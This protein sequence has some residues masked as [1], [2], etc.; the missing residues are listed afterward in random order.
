MIIEKIRPIIFE[1]L[2][3]SGKDYLRLAFSEYTQHKHVCVTRMFFSS[4]VY[5]ILYGRSGDYMQHVRLA[6]KFVEQFKPLVVY[7]DAKDFTLRKRIEERGEPRPDIYLMRQ[8]RK[9]Y[10]DVL[11]S[12]LEEDYIL[13]IDTTNSPGTGCAISS[14]LNRLSYLDKEN[15]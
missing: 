5:S 8:T 1:G 6:K 3:G 12:L 9:I 15:K 7:C 4:V 11:R 13:P 14:I 2:D 10:R